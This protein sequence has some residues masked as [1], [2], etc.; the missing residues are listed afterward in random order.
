MKYWAIKY[1]N[2]KKNPSKHE[3]YVQYSY[4]NIVC[5]N[6]IT[7]DEAYNNCICELDKYISEMLL[8]RE[9]LLTLR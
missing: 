9:E 5:A 7:K 6:G 2:D 8:I 4:E 1:N 3:V